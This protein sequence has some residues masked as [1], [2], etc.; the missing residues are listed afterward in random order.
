MPIFPLGQINTTA[1]EVAD[2]YI[3]IVPPQYL[4]NGVPS[5]I[6]GLVGAASWGPID[7]PQTFGSLAQY[8]AIFGPLKNRA[9]DMGTWAAICFELGAT[10]IKGVRVTDGSEARATVTV[11]TSCLTINSKWTGTHGNT[12]KVYIGPGSRPSTTMVRVSM[13]GLLPEIFDNL[14]G[15]GNA[16]WLAMASAINNGIPGQRG[17]SQMITATAGAGTAAPTTA[18]LSLSGGTD[19]ASGLEANDL[20]GEDTLPRKGMYALRNQN[21]SL[22]ALC[23]VTD[24]TLW[25]TQNTFGSREGIMM[26]SAGAA[27]QSIATA[28]SN[29]NNAGLDD[30]ASKIL[31]G[32]HVY[33][34]DSYNGIPQRLVSPAPFAMGKYL[35]LAPHR[36][37]LNKRVSNIAATEKSMTGLPYTTAD[38][39]ELALGNIDV[40]CNPA[41]GGNYFALRNGRNASSSP[42][43]RNDTYTRMTNYIAATLNRGMGI[44]IGELQSRQ[45]KDET[46]RRAKATL[47]A[48]LTA[49]KQQGQI[50]DFQVVLDL[51]NN[52][53][54][55][56][57]LGYMQADVQV[58]YMSVVEYFIINV[59]GGQTVEIKRVS[60]EQAA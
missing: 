59:E 6:G 39:Q 9:F 51:T 57:A 3:Q 28:R 43:T 49:M 21:V 23:D 31:L 26:F 2:V 42:A 25:A 44:Y 19:G 7:Q 34:N 55:R 29:K 24:H 13:P 11:Q 37:G 56:I 47:D 52:T 48:F 4:L 53:P 1:L 16:L 27:G 45:A 36:S 15:S 14:A 54:Q 20:I 40:I 33:W 38:L 12:T 50:D 18:T 30:Y 58:V 41:P 10:A 46:R 32:D 22:A 17:P 35:A 60:L 5:N 8:Q